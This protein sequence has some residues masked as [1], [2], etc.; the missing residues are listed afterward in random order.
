VMGVREWAAIGLS[1]ILGEPQAYLNAAGEW[2]NP[3]S[4]YH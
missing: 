2:T 4:L 3:D 1:L